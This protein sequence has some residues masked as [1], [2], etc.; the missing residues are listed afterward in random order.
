M[1]HDGARIAALILLAG[2]SVHEPDQPL[3]VGPADAG[4]LM[5]AGELYEAIVSARHAATARCWTDPW[6]AGSVG[7][8]YQWPDGAGHEIDAMVANG[9]VVFDARAG[10]ACLAALAAFACATDDP[11][12]LAARVDAVP[13]CLHVFSGTHPSE[14]TC[15][16]NIECIDQWCNTNYSCPGFCNPGPSSDAW[17]APDAGPP[18]DVGP[19]DAAVVGYCS[20]QPVPACSHP[21][22]VAAE[23]E[24][25]G[26]P[27]GILCAPGLVCGYDEFFTQ[28]HHCEQPYDRGGR[29][30]HAVPE[31]CPVGQICDGTLCVDLR[32]EG[33]PCILASNDRYVCASGLGCEQ[34]P[35]DAG[36][37]QTCRRG[38]PEGAA[39]EGYALCAGDLWCNRQSI[40]SP[41]TLRQCAPYVPPDVGPLSFPDTGGIDS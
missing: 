15:T 2:C 19:I 6:H 7:L 1:A 40:C 9:D 30:H 3:D 27:D 14:S 28:T 34:T 17:I 36:W 24:L 37:T 4:P 39:C 20:D 8:D 21:Q 32:G 13:E 12:S 18:I 33:Q 26:T 29:C 11:W 41:P 5:A 22:L 35:S 10:A 25:C 23:G 38:L 31:G 16:A